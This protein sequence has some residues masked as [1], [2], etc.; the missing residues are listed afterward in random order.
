MIFFLLKINN[1][2][3]FE[4]YDPFAVDFFPNLTPLTP[5]TKLLLQKVC[6]LRR[7][8]KCHFFNVS[9][10]FF[11]LISPSINTPNSRNLLEVGTAEISVCLFDRMPLLWFFWGQNLSGT[12]HLKLQF[13][14]KIIKFSW[15]T[16]EFTKKI[17]MLNGKYHL[18]HEN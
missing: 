3:I 18:N 14:D 10:S 12:E 15:K 2:D 17:A 7:N 9:H 6:I 11:F 13:F 5:Y 4:P 1:L 8:K 16:N